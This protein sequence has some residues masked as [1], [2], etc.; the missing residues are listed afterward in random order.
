MTRPRDEQLEAKVA[1]LEA[2]VARLEGVIANLTAHLEAATRSA[3][4]HRVIEG[5]WGTG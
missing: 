4:E 5:P 2:T 3:R 1:E